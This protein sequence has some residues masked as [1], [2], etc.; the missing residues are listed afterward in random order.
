MVS[1]L[2]HEEARKLTVIPVAFDA[3]LSFNSM[4]FLLMS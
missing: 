4:L 1:D 3:S 2:L